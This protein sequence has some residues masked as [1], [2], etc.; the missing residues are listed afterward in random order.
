MKILVK[1]IILIVLLSSSN[2]T[3]VLA[4]DKIKLGLLVPISGEFSEIGKSIIK[5]TLLAI[6]KIDD[7]LIEIIPKDTASNPD[8]TYEKAK[9]LQEAGVKIVIGPVFN[10]NLIKLEELSDMTFL[11]LT[12]KIIDNPK[13]IIS[14][15]INAGS[16]LN[17]I[18]KF[19]KDNEL[20]KTIFLI[21]NKNYKN[22]IKKAIKKS[23]IKT[24]KVHYYDSDPT[25]LTKQIEK[26]TKY[27]QRKQNVKDEIKR[28]KNSEDPN[29]DKKIKILEKRDTMGKIG[30]DSLII[31]DF[32]E[33]LKS[34]ATSLLYTD[35]SPKKTYFI[36]L[37]QWFDESLIKETSYQPIYYPSINKENYD[38]FTNTYFEKFNQY[39]NQL[40]FLSYDLVGLV[41]YLIFKNNGSIDK[42]IFSEKNKFKGKV[43]IF[44]IKDKKINHV[45]NFYKIENNNIKKIFWLF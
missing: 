4:Q 25:K 20:K 40:S 45:L 42:K 18:A 17:T 34:I 7:P 16:Q 2:L 38:E 27:S 37:N 8:V 32:D 43:G 22:E 12:N 23:K 19:Q 3:R 5:S 11:S 33:S 24:F 9:Q 31:A 44:E 15:G 35:V 10:K 26:I 1:I 21:P 28:L 41:Y 29:K 13:N 6:N 36:T 30:F 14:T 39:P